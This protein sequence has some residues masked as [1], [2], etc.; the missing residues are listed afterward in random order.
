M[1]L[2]G[3]AND[4]YFFMTGGNLV[5]AEEK[6]T[7]TEMRSMPYMAINSNLKNWKNILLKLVN[8]GILLN[9]VNPDFSEDELTEIEKAF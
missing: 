9:K 2:F 4:T 7:L 5:P 3:F 8:I 1:S 6:D